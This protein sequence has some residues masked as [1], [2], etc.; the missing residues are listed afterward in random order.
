MSNP[1]LVQY[2][3]KKNSHSTKASHLMRWGGVTLLL[4]IVW[5]LLNFTIG[6]I[7]VTGGATNDPYNLLVD[8]FET[9]WLTLIY[10]SRVV[11]GITGGNI[12][13]AQATAWRA[14]SGTSSGAFQNAIIASPIYLSI[15]PRFSMTSPDIGVRKS[16]I[17]CDMRPICSF[18]RRSS[19]TA[20]PGAAG[21]R[22]AASRR[23]YS[24]TVERKEISDRQ[25][26]GVL[27]EAVDARERAG[28]QQL[29][30]D[31]QVPVALGQ[32][33][34]GKVGVDALAVHDQGCK[35]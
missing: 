9:W 7:N 21:T 3:M 15:V 24:S 25:L 33:P 1:E 17:S 26:D 32:R 13:T 8:S 31:A 5:H 23:D 16:F 12:S 35:Q 10:L 34:L 14:W 11:D 19:W 29:A 27:L 2:V 22:E 30:V 6:K 18:I 4:F 20:A 28:R